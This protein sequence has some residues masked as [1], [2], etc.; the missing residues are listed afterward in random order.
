VPPDVDPRD[1]SADQQF[2]L[3]VTVRAF[4]RV[5]RRALVGTARIVGIVTRRSS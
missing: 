1:R 3:A 5:Q 4:A 2:L